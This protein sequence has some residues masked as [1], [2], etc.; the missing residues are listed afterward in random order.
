MQS[1]V[2]EI[3]M[4]FLLMSRLQCLTLGVRCRR[5]KLLYTGGKVLSA[6]L[7][8]FRSIYSRASNLR[9]TEMLSFI[10]YEVNI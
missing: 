3:D 10:Y 5:G 1:L 4:G 9:R 2:Q 6:E 7:T 8:V